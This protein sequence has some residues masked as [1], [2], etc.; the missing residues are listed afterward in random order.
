VDCAHSRTSQ[1]PNHGR[2]HGS[3]GLFQ[4][5]AL[6]RYDQSVRLARA[7]FKATQRAFIAIQSIKPELTTRANANVPLDEVAHD[8][9]LFVTRFAVQPIWENRGSTP[10]QAMLVNVDWSLG[11]QRTVGSYRRPDR[12]FFIAPKSIEADEIFEMP[13]LNQVIQGGFGDALGPIPEMLRS[14]PGGWCRSCG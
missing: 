14:R 1:R 8:P 9:G 12:R 13:G 4:W 3:D 5:Y 11:G 10:S 2:R 7:E 6:V